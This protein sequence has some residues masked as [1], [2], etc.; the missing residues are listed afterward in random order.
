MRARHGLRV[1][2]LALPSYIDLNF[3]LEDANGNRSLLKVASAGTPRSLR[4]LVFGNLLIVSAFLEANRIRS[5]GCHQDF[6]M[7]YGYIIL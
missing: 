4:N 1:R 2:A 7:P 5:R 3:R 6:L